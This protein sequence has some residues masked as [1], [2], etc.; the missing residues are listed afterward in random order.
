[1][2]IKL[3]EWIFKVITLGQCWLCVVISDGIFKRKDQIMIQPAVINFNKVEILGITAVD[4]NTLS[5]ILCISK[6]YDEDLK[7]FGHPVSYSSEEVMGKALNLN[8]I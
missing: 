2:V 1:M 4:P 6:L 3:R 7:M 8:C 5:E